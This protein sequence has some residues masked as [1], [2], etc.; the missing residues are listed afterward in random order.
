MTSASSSCGQH[1]LPIG[2]V[3]GVG[4]E[5]VLFDYVGAPNVV[6]I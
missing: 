3:G 1:A 4:S 5:T 6:G 2:L